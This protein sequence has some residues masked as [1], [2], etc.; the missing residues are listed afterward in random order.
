MVEETKEVAA[1][2]DVDMGEAEEVEEVEGAVGTV[3]RR[4][5]MVQVERMRR[6]VVRSKQVRRGKGR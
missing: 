5:A 2:V 1:D 4:G 6:R 3:I